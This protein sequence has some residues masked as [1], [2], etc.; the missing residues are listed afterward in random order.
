MDQRL[1]WSLYAHSTFCQFVHRVIS[2]YEEW[3][4]CPVSFHSM[5]Q[6]HGINDQPMELELG[7]NL[8]FEVQTALNQQHQWIS[9][10]FSLSGDV[11]LL[12]LHHG[13][14][15]LQYVRRSDMSADMPPDTFHGVNQ[16]VSGFTI[17]VIIADDTVFSIVLL[18]QWDFEVSVM[19]CC[20]KVLEYELTETFPD[21]WVVYT[22]N[23]PPPGMSLP[24]GLLLKYWIEHV[25]IGLLYV[26]F[27]VSIRIFCKGV[28]GL[29]NDCP[30]RQ[31]VF[32]AED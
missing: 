11:A 17:L 24:L 23:R 2:C 32:V 4:S 25:T 29:P 19:S 21:N 28:P 20:S 14:I 6:S 13:Y 12:L 15:C 27:I 31:V 10:L 30:C 1:F 9:E 8:G 5:E 18:W 16:K 7:P 3:W 22:S 26:L